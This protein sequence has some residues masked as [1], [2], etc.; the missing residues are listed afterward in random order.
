[1]NHPRL[2]EA[3]RAYIDSFTDVYGGDPFMVRLLLQAGRF[4]VFHSAAV[5]E[6]AQDPS[7]RETW[8][9]VAALKKQ[10]AMFG[11]ASPRQVDHLVARLREVG[12]LEQSRAPDDRRVWLLA[13]TNKLRAH[14]TEWLAAHYVPLA[15]LYPHHDYSPVLSHDRAFHELH[16]RACLPFTA[17]GARLMMTLPDTLLF[18]MHAAGPLIQNALLKAAMDSGDLT[19]AVPYI[20]VADRFGVSRTHVRNLMDSA[21]AAGLVRIVG[22]GGRSIE[23]LPRHWVS[24][25][26]GLAVGMYLHDVVN[27]VVMQEWAKRPGEK[28]ARQLAV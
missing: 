14:H 26:R 17:V 11:Y 27:L 16:C 21:Q 6:A 15:K 24:Y 12:F 8:F 25:D 7:R 18:F 3:R 28:A 1:M 23:I 4:F 20:D 10:L 5:L 2:P 22:R 9:T 13:T 19:A